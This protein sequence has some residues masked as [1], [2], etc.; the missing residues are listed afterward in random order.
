MPDHIHHPRAR[1]DGG[2]HI[3]ATTP[4]LSLALARGADAIDALCGLPQLDAPGVYVALDDGGAYCGGSSL[5]VAR[6]VARFTTGG[7]GAAPDALIAVVG[8]AAPLSDVDARALERIVHQALGHAGLRLRN[9]VTPEGA[10]V[11]HARYAALQGVWAECLAAL[12]D[13]APALAHPWRGPDYL[14]P[15]PDA[16]EDPDPYRTRWRATMRGVTASLRSC[17]NGYVLEAGGQLR[18][19]PIPS[20]PALCWTMREELAFCGAIVREPDRWRLT[21]DLW[22]PTLSACARVAF[23]SGVAQCW[24]VVDDEAELGLITPSAL[25]H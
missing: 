5:S 6:R 15:P 18:L 2:L 4:A 12:R 23:T 10:P 3:L 1:R 13:V 20:A 8:G 14:T 16:G 7:A 17:A 11:G 25:A 19:T 22:L 21:R 24:R 9:R